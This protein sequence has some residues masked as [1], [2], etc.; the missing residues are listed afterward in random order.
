MT[1]AVE[2]AVTPYQGVADSTV[3]RL[4]DKGWH[5]ALTCQYNLCPVHSGFQHV[6]W[7]NG[8]DKPLNPC[9]VQRADFNLS[10]HTTRPVHP[11]VDKL[12]VVGGQADHNARVLTLDT[13][14]GI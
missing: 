2:L 7:N 14:K 9:S 1:V 10:V 6:G 8:L 5:V 12:G 4:L 3:G 11:L 13:V